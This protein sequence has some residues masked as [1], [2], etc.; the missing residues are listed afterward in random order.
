MST[1]SGLGHDAVDLSTVGEDVHGFWELTFVKANTLE[2][3]LQDL[4]CEILLSPEEHVH[5]AALPSLQN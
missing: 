4:A 2:S 5:Y 1:C 3:L